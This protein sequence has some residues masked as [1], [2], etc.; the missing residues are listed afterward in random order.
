MVGAEVPKVAPAAMEIVFVMDTTGSM[1][2]LLQGAKDKVWSIAHDVLKDNPRSTLRMGI[3][4][5]RDRDSVSAGG[6]AVHEE[7]VTKDFDLTDDLDTLY[8]QL[9]SLQAKGGGTG[10]R[11]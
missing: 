7:Y 5:Y 10:R 2:R 6:T 4:A 1:T 11:A 9:T 8:R 3:V